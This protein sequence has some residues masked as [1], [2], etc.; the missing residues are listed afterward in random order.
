MMQTGAPEE[1]GDEWV[2]RLLMNG[3]NLSGLMKC[4]PEFQHP[5][6]VLSSH[7]PQQHIVLTFPIKAKNHI[8]Q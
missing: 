7:A 8:Y 4:W 5:H 3:N 6:P 1:I 2:V